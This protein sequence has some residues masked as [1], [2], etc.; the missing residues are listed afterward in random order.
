MESSMPQPKDDLSKS[1]I[2][3]D[4]HKTLIAV[5]ELC[6]SSWLVGR[7]VPGIRRDALKKLVPDEEALHHLL[8]RWRDEAVKAGHTIRA[9]LSPSRPAAT[10]FGWRDGCVHAVLKLTSF[11]PRASQSH[12]SI[13]ERRPIGWISGSSSVP[14]SAGC[15][16]SKSTAAWLRSRRWKKRMRS[17]P[18]VNTNIWLAGV[19]ASSTV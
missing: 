8:N 2:A 12:V 3:F 11:I 15:A 19:R 9:L 4:Q 16:A 14:F 7:I 10:A 18:T 6:L 13:G 1:L 17:A 5:V